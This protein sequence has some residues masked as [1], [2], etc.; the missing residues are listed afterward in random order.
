MSCLLVLRLEKTAAESRQ[1]D[2]Q[3]AHLRTAN[4]QIEASLERA[5]AEISQLL[6]QLRVSL[7]SS[8][9][10]IFG[11]T[12]YLLALHKSALHASSTWG[13]PLH[14]IQSR[15]IQRISCSF[16]QTLAESLDRFVVVLLCQP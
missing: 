4:A 5:K 7:C 8:C 9:T 11:R 1:A 16:I 6:D 14:I 15:V 12:L 10:S 13:C 2:V 3:V